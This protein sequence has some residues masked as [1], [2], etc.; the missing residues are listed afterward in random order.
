MT[1]TQFFQLVLPCILIG[2]FFTGL[3]FPMWVI[4][5]RLGCNPALSLM[6]VVPLV[7][8]AILYHVAFSN[9]VRLERQ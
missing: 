5:R 8:I 7:N 9:R 2:I 4:F 6:L 1:E 3:I